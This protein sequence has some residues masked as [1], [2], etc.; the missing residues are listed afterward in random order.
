[1]REEDNLSKKY[2][3][4]ICWRLLEKMKPSDNGQGKRSPIN[5][6]EENALD[7]KH[8]RE[9][10]IL[11]KK[12]LL[13]EKDCVEGDSKARNNE[14]EI[15]DNNFA[16]DK[17]KVLVLQSLSLYEHIRPYVGHLY[18]INRAPRP[19]T[20]QDQLSIFIAGKKIAIR[21]E[22]QELGLDIGE[23]KKAMIKVAYELFATHFS[24]KR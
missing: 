5:L 2:L 6:T 11:K 4:K 10:M 20:I 12:G 3:R 1:M 14:V 13:F 9:F 24:R 8:I 17:V 16:D 21:K 19:S 15:L 7:Y 23:G 18:K 22:K